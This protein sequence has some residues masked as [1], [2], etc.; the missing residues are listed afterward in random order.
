MVLLLMRRT[1]CFSVDKG[2][3]T[4]ILPPLLLV[5]VAARRDAVFLSREAGPYVALA[6]SLIFHVVVD[7]T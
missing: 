4:S 7:D 1:I 6:I 5:F 3:P 2:N